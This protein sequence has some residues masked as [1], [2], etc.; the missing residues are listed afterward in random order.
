[1]KKI[2]TLF[3]LLTT[4]F[5]LTGCNTIE[6]KEHNVYVTVY[7]VQYL[8]EEL[9][10]DTFAVNIVPGFTNHSDSVSWSAKDI[11]AMKSADLLFYLEGGFDNYIPNNEA[12]FDGGE[13]SLYSLEEAAD[14]AHFC[15]THEH[16]HD[17]EEHV[18]ETHDTE[19]EADVYEDPHFW[20][21]PVR[22]SEVADYIASVL[23]TTFTDKVD[24]IDENLVSL[25]SKLTTLDEAY[26]EALHDSTKPL[27]LTSKLF[28]YIEERYHVEMLSITDDVHASTTVPDDIIH[29]VEEA[30]FHN[31]SY[32]LYEKYSNSPAGD[33]VL[34]DL[35]KINPDAVRGDL[36]SLG[37]LTE[38]E[39]D[40][41]EDYISLMYDN[42]EVLKNAIK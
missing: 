3:L 2:I 17:E 26:H 21:D 32:I 8:V 28:M 38:E 13:V 29:F 4:I 11:I 23:K 31:I 40:A 27:L 41:S 33:V 20:L 24:I 18:E 34:E 12:I 37:Q 15:G 25:Q 5:V 39:K 10:D 6:T 30:E 19:C 9:V 22:M 7:P 1:M 14:Y 42:L 35:L 36:H 16:D